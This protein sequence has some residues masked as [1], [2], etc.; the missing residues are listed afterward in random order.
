MVPLLKIRLNCFV[1]KK[2]K[3]ERERKGNI[4]SFSL[5]LSLSLS[6]QTYTFM[7]FFTLFI[8]SST[9]SHDD[10]AWMGFK[11]PFIFERFMFW[12]TCGQG[13]K[14]KKKKWPLRFL[15]RG[16]TPFFFPSLPTWLIYL[17]FDHQPLLNSMEIDTESI[18]KNFVADQDIASFFENTLRCSDWRTTVTEDLVTTWLNYIRMNHNSIMA[19]LDTQCSDAPQSDFG[20]RETFLRLLIAYL[21]HTQMLS[22]FH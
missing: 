6:L 11:G 2:K 5:P 21:D 1:W 13:R 16:R 20:V 19:T 10:T 9:S 12:K 7:F 18:A 22:F 3:R 4:L 14:W 8:G 17:L 15:K